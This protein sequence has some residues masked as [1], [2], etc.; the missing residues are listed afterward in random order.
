MRP[1]QSPQNNLGLERAGLPRP[2][3][4]GVHSLT[5]SQ[6]PSSV[7]SQGFTTSQSEDL[8]HRKCSYGTMGS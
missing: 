5:A 7:L 1:E 3:A 4:H 2:Q 8:R 6:E